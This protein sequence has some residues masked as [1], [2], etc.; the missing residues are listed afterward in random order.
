[1]SK[2]IDRTGQR[3]GR[4]VALE[5]VAPA[6]W[7]CVCDCGTQTVVANGQLRAGKTKSCG[8]LR[9][10]LATTASTSHGKSHLPSY[11]AWMEMRTRCQNPKRHDYPRYGGAG[12][13]VCDRWQSYEAFFEDMGERPPG[14]TLD[15]RDNTKGYEPGNVRW[16]TA[17]EQARNKTNNH[18]FDGK[19]IAQ[20]AEELGITH[21]A[22]TNRIA[23]L[24][25]P[26]V[27]PYRT[28]SRRKPKVL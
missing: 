13:K 9:K 19:C 26:Y 18:L 28:K 6:K 14:L 20:I 3:Y 2:R 22:V 10:E 16:A 25:T 24:G 27:T 7:R 8:C 1:M 4:L 17:K 21:G 11:T 5:Y 15:R 23:K 12:V